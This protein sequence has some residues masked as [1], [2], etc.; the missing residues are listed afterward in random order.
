MGE[1]KTAWELLQEEQ[2]RAND[3][4]LFLV[5][6]CSSLIKKELNNST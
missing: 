4:C 6:S 2:E 3:N 5:E 1:F